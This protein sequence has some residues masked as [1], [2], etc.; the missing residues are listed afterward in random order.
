MRRAIATLI[1][2]ASLALPYADA[3]GAATAKPVVKI[4]K[5]VSTKTI[6]G[7]AAEADRWGTVQ[8]T[9][10]VQQTRTTTKTTIKSKTTTKTRVTNRITDVRSAY[11]IHTDRSQFIMSE[12]LPLLKQEVL[13]AQSANVQMISHATDTSEAFQQSLQAA[14][15]QVA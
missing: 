14:V 2:T 8:V 1:G 5:K 3:A 15:S 9:I 4:V 13:T 6:A 12:A 11:E 7:P 10:V